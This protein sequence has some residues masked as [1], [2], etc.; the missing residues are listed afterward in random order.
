MASRRRLVIAALGVLLLAG[1]G[2]VSAR[3][4]WGW[5]QFQLA[6]TALDDLDF[7][8]AGELLLSSLRVRADDPDALLARVRAL[9]LAHRADEAKL[10]LDVVSPFPGKSKEVAWEELFLAA[11]RGS[12]SL[13]DEQQLLLA[14]ERFPEQGNDA[15]EAVLL[16]R[17]RTYRL[18]EA[19]QL[20]KDW[21][22]REPGHAPAHYLHGLLL[23]GFA[24]LG[25][26]A[27][28]Y[29]KAIELRPAYA[30]PR[31]R[32]AEC[33]LAL[34]VPAAA[35]PHFEQLAPRM[36]DPFAARFGLARCLVQLGENDAAR[37]LVREIA[38]THPHLQAVWQLQA[39]IAGNLGQPD[40]ALA[41]LRK[42]AELDPYD[43]HILYALS[44]SLQ[45]MG[46]LQEAALLLQKQQRIQADLA[47][48]RKLH[49]QIAE[50]PQSLGERRDAARVCFRNGQDAEALRWLDG[51]LLLAPDDRDT[52]LLLAEH[53]ERK[54][55]APLAASHRH[56]AGP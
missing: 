32:L 38:A 44:Q 43:P 13:A 50:R 35:R 55:D 52:H 12:M 19:M 16:G 25:D 21:L 22:A 11:Q 53:H 42:A 33:Q 34:N 4:Y 48:L 1:I 15:I 3:S 40:Q 51:V 5:R 56:R 30:G 28:N 24:Q 47:Q 23:E 10:A 2:Y 54:G 41:H 29:Q 18:A 9:R 31:L 8:R 27:A 17:M 39:R 7:D 49:E 37:P 36:K 46:Q 45:Q 26:A 20:A 14:I 6:L